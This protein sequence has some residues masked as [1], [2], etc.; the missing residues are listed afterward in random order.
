MPIA[1]ITILYA[2]LLMTF[3]GC[4]QQTQVRTTKSTKTTTLSL[5]GL[6]CEGC[7][8]RVVRVLKMQKGVRTATFDKHKVEVT[9]SYEQQ[10][11][12]EAAMIKKVKGIGFEAFSGPG[13]GAY[14]PP[15]TYSK[16]M[17]V[18]WLSKKGERVDISKHIVKGKVT[19][20]DFYAVWCGP[21]K[22][23]DHVLF[24][25]LKTHK[26]I[27]LRKINVVDW[28]RPVAKQYMSNVSKLPFLIIYDKQG[29]KA[30]TIVGR[31]LEEVKK[32]LSTLLKPSQ[33]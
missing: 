25:Q 6:T 10:T 12:S 31:E 16:E 22:D 17:D 15:P 5:R 13:K 30:K 26:D 33:K 11:T 7:G 3:A 8:A 18:K 1:R 20:F 23:V 29:N 32:T 14:K 4:S 9:L 24:Q 19:V 27:A 28:D 21:C 2:A